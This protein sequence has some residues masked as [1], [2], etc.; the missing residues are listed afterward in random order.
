[1]S[2]PNPVNSQKPSI[3]N[4]PTQNEIDHVSQVISLIK[5]TGTSSDE[6]NRRFI[7]WIK[8]HPEFHAAFFALHSQ[9]KQQAELRAQTSQRR[10]T[11][12]STMPGSSSLST[13]FPTSVSAVVTS[14]ISDAS[15]S[16]LG[17]SSITGN[18]VI[19]PSSVSASSNLQS[20]G[21]SRTQ[22]QNMNSLP[23]SS[24]PV[25]SASAS[26]GS[27]PTVVH[28]PVQWISIQSPITTNHH[29]PLITGCTAQP[30]QAVPNST[31][32]RFRAVPGTATLVQSQPQQVQHFYNTSQLGPDPTFSSNESGSSM[33]VSATGSNILSVG[34]QQ[35]QVL[36]AVP[37]RITP[38]SVSNMTT[39]GRQASTPQAAI[40]HFRS[41]QHQSL[42]GTVNPM[43][44][45]II[46]T[47][48]TAPATGPAHLSHQS[49]PQL[50]SAASNGRQVVALMTHQN[51]PHTN[52]S[53]PGVSLRD[54]GSNNSN[55]NLGNGV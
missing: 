2:I 49:Q 14:S 41:Q 51:I 6:Q 27:T 19:V 42:S 10:M 18:V 1:V 34:N 3:T 25:V 5:A 22:T 55:N 23:M 8:R 15:Q 7:A 21:L 29:Q 16:L 47:N 20:P 33:F 48:T 38:A 37:Q 50:V 24:M 11:T 46:L 32:L 43:Q 52:V 12:S 30:I 31:T 53:D 17:S 4:K 54:S 36:S 44:P 13:S 28:Q 35:S 40:V 45:H 39:M 9:H 26:L